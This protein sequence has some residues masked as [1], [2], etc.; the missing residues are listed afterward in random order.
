MG[1]SSG[2]N[3]IWRY[4]DLR[5]RQS[6]AYVKL[7]APCGATRRVTPETARK[8]AVDLLEVAEYCAESPPRVEYVSHRLPGETAGGAAHHCS[9]C[10]EA[11]PALSPEKQAVIDRTVDK[12]DDEWEA[13]AKQ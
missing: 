7:I 12:T 6:G 2:Q 8:I 4:G 11:V 3:R 5:V 1:L 13:L 9:K 10:G